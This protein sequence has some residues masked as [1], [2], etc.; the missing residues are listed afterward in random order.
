MSYSWKVVRSLALKILCHGE[1]RLADYSSSLQALE[2][3]HGVVLAE[4]GS[5]TSDAHS[6]PEMMVASL[7]FAC[8]CLQ[9]FATFSSRSCYVSS[10]FR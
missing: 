5:A 4:G 9:G 1:S 6:W 8:L 7:F 10:C 2:S 3:V